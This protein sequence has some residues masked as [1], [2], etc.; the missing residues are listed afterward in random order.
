M[1]APWQPGTTYAPGAT[2][3]PTTGAGTVVVTSAPNN[4]DFDSDTSGWSALDGAFGWQSTG[5][6]GS[7]GMCTL[8]AGAGDGSFCN[9]NHVPVVVGQRIAASCMFMQGHSDAGDA[10]GAV[11]V[12]W[13]DAN[14]ELLDRSDGNFI[15]SS[16]GGWWQRSSVNAVA[17]PGAAFA[18]V[19]FIGNNVGSDLC[20][21]DQVTWDYAYTAPAAPLIYTA[22]QADP[23]HSGATEPAWP[24]TPGE[25]VVDNEVTWMCGSVERVTW[26]CSPLMKSGDTEPTFPT[27]VGAEVLDNTVNWKCITP[28][29]TD[30]NCPQSK[31]I[32]MAATK[33]FAA[34][35]D[36]IR[37]CA[38]AN[39]LDWSTDQDAG[40]LPF[41]LQSFGQNPAAAMNLYRGN[42]VIFNTEGC[43]MW[44]VDEDPLNMALLDAVPIGSTQHKALTPVA[45]DLFLLSPLGV[46][47]MGIAAGSQNLMAGDVGMP[48]DSLVQADVAEAT[49]N[50]VVPL[51]TYYPAQGQFWLAIPGVADVFF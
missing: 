19:G 39:P 51:A 28:Q 17:P 2:C 10:G 47:T 15:Q 14:D 1:T 8:G 13:F 26:E 7:P 38:T 41:G 43:Q 22:V 11:S 37:Y 34:D 24:T 46:R 20:A 50:G 4:P 36:I 3:V 45:N 30:P 40:F 29:I 12:F 25:T 16:A 35:T 32:A 49:A 31:V 5:G 23:G 48:I 6:Y 27:V 42:L 33:V 9:D 18:A 21:F 44:Q